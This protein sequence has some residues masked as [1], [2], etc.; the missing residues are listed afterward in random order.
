MPSLTPAEIRATLQTAPYASDDLEAAYFVS[1]V[2]HC[3][4]DPGMA[5]EADAL[6]SAVRDWDADSAEEY[7]AETPRDLI[8][9]SLDT[10][11]RFLA[12]K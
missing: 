1:G 3:S 8:L 12:A 11:E 7:G 2:L 5:D 6:V 4:G 10:L 9:A